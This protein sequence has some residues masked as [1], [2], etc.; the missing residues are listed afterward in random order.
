MIDFKSTEIKELVE[1]S[2]REDI[3]NGDHSSL[4]SIPEN[5][6]GN[7]K[8]IFKEEAIVAGLELCKLVFKIVDKNLEITFF[9]NEG[10]LVKKGEVILKV[11]GKVH[12]ILAA[13]RTALNFIQR[14]SG[15]AT[16]TYKINDMIKDTNCKILDTRKTTPGLRILEK[17]AVKIGGGYNHR[18]G[19][20]DM[21]MLKD[22]H[23]DFAGGITKAVKN[24][25][26]YLKHKNLN[27]KIEVETRNLK[28]V[29]EAMKID[30]V[31][32]I[33]LDNFSPDMIINALTLINK[34]K[35]TEASGGITIDN[36]RNYALTGIDYISI[37]ALTHSVKCIDI[38]LKQY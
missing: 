30:S 9:K 4:A 18:I 34:R 27:L 33:M 19:L 28:E 15:I 20:F 37:G 24:T 23:I 1:N 12:S 21:V 35:E 29:E 22:N 38:S 14:L 10:D 13:E 6:N 2:L 36:I 11:S 31:D 8:M 16:I 17:W 5:T 7:A 32:R 26:E 3:G 25:E